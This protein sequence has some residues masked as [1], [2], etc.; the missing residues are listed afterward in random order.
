MDEVS[1]PNTSSWDGHF[2]RIRTYLDVS[3][4]LKRGCMIRFSTD[5]PVWVEFRYEKL[6]VFCCFCGRV[7]HE[8][9]ACDKRFLDLEEDFV[10]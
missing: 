3:Q 4:P 7:G 9:L 8:L 2:L 5:P 1:I 6:P 10:A